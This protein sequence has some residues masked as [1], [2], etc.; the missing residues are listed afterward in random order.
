MPGYIDRCIA[1]FAP[2]LVSH[3]PPTP[4]TRHTN[5]S[6]QTTAQKHSSHRTLDTTPRLSTSTKTVIQEVVGTILYY[7]RTIDSTV[8][9]ALGSI[10]TQQSKP[11]ATTQKAINY[12]LH[13]DATVRFYASDMILNLHSDTKY[14]SKS[15]TRSRAG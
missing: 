14:L 6:S 3:P 12:L 2:H 11:T 15:G 8:L 5:R 13:Y 4:N 9:V 1:R 10:R 7:G